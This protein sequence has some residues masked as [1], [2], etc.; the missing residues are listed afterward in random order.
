MKFKVDEN[1]PLDWATRLRAADYD[2]LSVID[3][4]LGGHPDAEVAAV[5]AREERVLI[6]LDTD[7]SNILAYPPRNYFGIM[8]I[9]SADQSIPALN[10]LLDYV[11][12]ALKSESIN[13]SLWIVEKDRIRI[14]DGT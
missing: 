8:V 6:T 12:K 13:R 2:A 7:F 14:R 9:R 3:Q 5:C 11:L 10:R 1:L 4:Q